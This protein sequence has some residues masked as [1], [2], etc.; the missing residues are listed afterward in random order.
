[1]GL[2]VECPST[3]PSGAKIVF[4]G[5]APGR[6]EVEAREGFVGAA[7]RC[8]QRAC[9][10]AGIDWSVAGRTNVCKRRPPDNKFREAFYETVEEPIYTK[11]G[12]VSKK[13]KK[14]TRP[15]D[16]L[17]DWRRRLW[18]EL[19][20]QRPNLVVA[21]GN[22]ALEALTEGI[23]GITNYRGS[24]LPGRPEVDAKVLAALHPSYII[25]GQHIE[26]WSL[27]YDLKKARR[28]MEFREIRREPFISES[29]PNHEPSKILSYLEAIR[30]KPSLRFTLDVETR[31]GTLACFSMAYQFPGECPLSFCIPIQTTTGPYWSPQAEAQIWKALAATAHSNPNLCNQN[32]LYDIDYLLHYGV[33][34]SGIYM[35]TMLAHSILYL[36]FPKGLDFLCSFYLDDVVYYKGEG[37]T[38]G[39][40]EPDQ[41]L[42][43]YCCKDAVYTLRVVE[44]IDEQLRTRGLWELYHG[45][46]EQR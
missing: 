6:E 4:V 15:T 40:K 43:A 5:E 29:D 41:Q 1:M 17:L 16:E 13:T 9:S 23:S 19:R 37:R 3:L 31:A 14:S 20:Q 25:R 2:L 10:V 44:K 24:I 32:V 36:E 45:R 42:W 35:D 18:T 26:F 11:T 27:V 46:K 12:K 38:W 28:E 39:A 33:E 8:L 30:Q 21:L 7:G 34:P 22:E